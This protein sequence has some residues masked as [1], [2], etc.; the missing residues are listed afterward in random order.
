MT[1]EETINQYLYYVQNVRRR[2]KSTVKNKRIYLYR[3][4]K[5]VGSDLDILDLTN[6]MIDEYH[7]NMQLSPSAKGGVMS[8][9]TVNI[10]IR[11]IKSMLTFCREYLGIEPK[12]KSFLIHELKEPD[13]HPNIIFFSDVQKV[14]AAC[15]RWQD[16]LMIALTFESGL[17]I[18][19]LCKVRLEDFRR[20]T[21]DVVGKGEKHRITFLSDELY[22]EIQDFCKSRDI[23]S[24]YVFRPLNKNGNDHYKDTDTVRRRIEAEFKRT[25]GIKM[26]PHQLRH[27]FAINLLENGTNVRSIQKMLGHSK[28]ETTM[29]YLGISDK[30]L[31]EDYVAHFG[32]S[33][34]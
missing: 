3:F 21:L 20:T 34:L 24:G 15:N 10:S 7:V 30:Y 27:A 28:L 22:G 11:S 12:A 8:V 26:H 9:Y 13:N 32:G 29:R 23:G 18:A 4:A 25:M 33:V 17:R 31:K 5:S 2:A 16:R 6:Q 19:E 14:V 1:I